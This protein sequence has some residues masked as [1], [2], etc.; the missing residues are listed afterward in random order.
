LSEFTT[1]NKSNL[2][3][4]GQMLESMKILKIKK[5]SVLISP[6]GRRRKSQLTNEEVA[7]R[8]SGKRPFNNLSDLEIKKLIRFYRLNF[9]DLLKKKKLLK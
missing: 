3:F 9:G 6:K 5:N 2:T 8:V 7:E 1:P 4:S